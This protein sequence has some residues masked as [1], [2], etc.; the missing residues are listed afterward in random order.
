MNSTAILA[1]TG[2]AV[3]LSSLT[4]DYDGDQLFVCWDE[5]LI[6]S[7]QQMQ[8]WPSLEYSAGADTVSA[9]VNH[10][11][12][13]HYFATYDMHL[14]GRLNS[15]YLRWAVLK[16]ID[17]MECVQLAVLFARGVDAVKTGDKTAVPP[18]LIPPRLPLHADGPSTDGSSSDS[19]SNA[20][21]TS[22]SSSSSGPS[23][24][25]MPSM[26]AA[27]MSNTCNSHSPAP[28]VWV[29]LIQRAQQFVHSWQQQRITFSAL[30]DITCGL[31]LSDMQELLISRDIAAREYDLLRLAVTW[32]RQHGDEEDVELAELVKVLDFGQMTAQQVW[33]HS[34][35]LRPVAVTS[36][37]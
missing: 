24:A 11:A 17:C 6:P 28:R 3:L 20:A 18:H 27:G 32:Q 35:C 16:G 36:V 29:E 33:C 30:S 4:G 8:R 21:G 5:R 31:S 23:P 22:S 12:F 25:H 10:A 9:K 19:G 15:Y 7:R 13:V 2:P 14:L 34:W 26:S 1:A 37:C